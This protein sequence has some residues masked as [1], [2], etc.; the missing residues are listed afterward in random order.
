MLSF[1]KVNDNE[2][3]FSCRVMLC[4]RVML[5]VFCDVY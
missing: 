4:E 1:L 2:I 3:M 5:E